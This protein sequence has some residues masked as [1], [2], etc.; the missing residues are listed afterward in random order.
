[1][2]RWRSRAPGAD[3][4]GL[5]LVLDDLQWAD[6]ASRVLL[7]DVVRQLH[8]TRILLFATCRDTPAQ[9]SA[10]LLKLVPCQAMVARMS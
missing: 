1:M 5:L 2:R 3:Q 7:A 9:A 4:A 8:G 6:E 10:T